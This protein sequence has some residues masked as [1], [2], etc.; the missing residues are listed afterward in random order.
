MS[1]LPANTDIN[2]FGSRERLRE[3][4]WMIASESGPRQRAPE[5]MPRNGAERWLTRRLSFASQF[6]TRANART[7]RAISH[8]SSVQSGNSGEFRDLLAD[9][10]GFELGVR[11]TRHMSRK[12]RSNLHWKLTQ[13][14]LLW[15]YDSCPRL[16]VI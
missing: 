10:D 5:K 3:C 7:L 1:P 16:V 9:R 14:N 13:R 2:L 11:I 12:T 4:A 6:A 8:D 15:S